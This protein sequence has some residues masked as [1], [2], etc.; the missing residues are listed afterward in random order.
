MQL[1]GKISPSTYSSYIKFI[2]EASHALE[3]YDAIIDQS[4]KSNVFICNAVLSCVV[5]NGKSDSSMRL[6]Y[7]MKQDGLMPD[8]VTY[9]TVNTFSL[10]NLWSIFFGGFLKIE[11]ASFSI[12]LSCVYGIAGV[13]IRRLHF[14]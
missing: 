11:V 1:H 12:M 8:I 13:M 9:S 5:K 6:F 3:I 7:Q 10:S 4:M 2:Q 14:P